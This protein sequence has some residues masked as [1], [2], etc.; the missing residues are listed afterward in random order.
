ML[1]LQNY[2]IFVVNNVTWYKFGVDHRM[3]IVYLRFTDA[4]LSVPQL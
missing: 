2:Y 4:S 1:P 3:P